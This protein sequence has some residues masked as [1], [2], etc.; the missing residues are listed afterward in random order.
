MFRDALHP[1]LLVTSVAMT[2][3]AGSGQPEVEYQVFAVPEA[4]GV[5]LADEGYS[6]TID[7]ATV[8]F[9]PV[10][11]CASFS[12]S[13]TLCDAALGELTTVTAFDAKDTTPRPLGLAHGFTGTIQSASYDYG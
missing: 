13:A 4:A 2:A 12:G 11:F 1:L 9:G 8:A 7:T 3:C 10:Y 5:I 6:V